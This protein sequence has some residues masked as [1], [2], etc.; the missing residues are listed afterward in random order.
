MVWGGYL[1]FRQIAA[2]DHGL[3]R[4]EYLTLDWRFLLAG[5]RPAPRGVVIAAVDDETLRALGSY[6]VPRDTMARIVRQVA[7]YGPQAIALDILFLDPGNPD[8][9]AA[10]AEALRTIPSVVGAVGV[11]G[12]DGPS[13]GGTADLGHWQFI[14]SPSTC[15][16]ADRRGSRRGPQRARQ[17]V[18]R[19]C[20]RP[21][22]RPDDVSGRSR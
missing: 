6:P 18:H 7:T 22:F 16:L 9:D 14:P 4:I 17:S 5:A 8:S 13:A 1:G 2:L 15:S 12:R 21:A 19:Q 11:F 10:L 3:D 20:R